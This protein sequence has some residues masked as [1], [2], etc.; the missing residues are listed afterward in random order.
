MVAAVDASQPACAQASVRELS[1]ATKAGPERGATAPSQRG[2]QH[3]DA[4]QTD[5]PAAKHA[6]GAR[7]PAPVQDPVRLEL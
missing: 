7:N 1:E 4:G 5:K 3:R 6:D 2:H